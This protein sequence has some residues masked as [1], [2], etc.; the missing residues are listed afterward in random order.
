MS[1]EGAKYV[2]RP[3]PADTLQEALQVAQAI[4]DQNNGRPMNRVLL[5][6][7]IR[8]KPASSDFKYLLSSSAKYGLTTG[9]EK[10]PAIALTDLGVSISKAR[11]PAE[12]ASGLKRAAMQPEVFKSIYEHYDNG[13]LPQGQ[14]FLSVLERDF[15]VPRE[16]TQECADIAT[17]NGHF[18]GI[19]RELH[20]TA[21]VVLESSQGEPEVEGGLPVQAISGVEMGEPETLAAPPAAEPP[22]VPSG[23]RYI[24]IAHGK[25][26]TPLEQ[27]KKVLDQFKIRYRVAIDEPQKARPISVKVADTMRSCQSAIFIFSADEQFINSDGQTVW[28]PSQNVIYELGAASVLYGDKIVIFKEQDLDFP[29][30]FR[31]IGNIPFEKDALDARGVQ[32]IAELIALGLVAVQPT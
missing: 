29:T 20:Q 24:F 21:Y 23:E 1:S 7:A 2:R 3:F 13:K 10:S 27:L 9:N 12:R 30:D 32:L 11:D 8:R 5:A 15:K 26:R 16:R 6:A 14:F 28:R 31:D 17:A 4:Q 22:P 18:V 19:I 25:N